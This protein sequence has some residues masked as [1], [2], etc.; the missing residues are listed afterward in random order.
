MA[1]DRRWTMNSNLDYYVKTNE[2][3]RVLRLALSYKR[4]DGRVESVGTFVLDL[5]KLERRGLVTQSGDVFDIRVFRD[6]GRF[7]L[8]V[9]AADR[10]ALFEFQ[11]D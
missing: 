8:G 9:R 11:A 7:W 10:A 4:P 2:P 1:T 3:E 6:G 5:P